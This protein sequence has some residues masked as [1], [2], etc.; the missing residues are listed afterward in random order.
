MSHPPQELPPFSGDGPR[1]PKCL[2]NGA[3]TAYLGYG[4]C[5]HGTFN[6]TIGF[7]TNERLH[8]ECR[9][10]GYMWDEALAVDLPPGTPVRIDKEQLT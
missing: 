4:E 1:C 6:E 5:A 9:R 10:C 3:S 2:G 7:E 8:R